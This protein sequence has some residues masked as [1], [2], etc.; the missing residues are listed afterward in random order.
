MLYARMKQDDR[1]ARQLAEERRRAA[2]T[3]IQSAVRSRAARA[4]LSSRRGAA[5]EARARAREAGA[6]VIQSAWRC[7][8][9]R[10]RAHV[11]SGEKREAEVAR[12]ARARSALQIQCASRSRGAR[13]ICVIFLLLLICVMIT[14]GQDA[15]ADMASCTIL[16]LTRLA[17]YL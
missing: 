7:H 5:A 3:Q 2:C 12:A 16:N 1:D 13:L 14:G 6:L 10:R 4:E 15:R 8:C 9:S 17:H 11:L